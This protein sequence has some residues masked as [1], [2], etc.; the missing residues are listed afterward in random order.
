MLVTIG[1]I[2]L[3]IGAS[4]LF[5]LLQTIRLVPNQNEDFVFI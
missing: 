3:P 1:V 2:T 4:L 5:Q